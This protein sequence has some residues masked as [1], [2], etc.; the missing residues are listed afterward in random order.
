MSTFTWWLVI[1]GSPIV[2][3][4]VG[5]FL[6]YDYGVKQTEERWSEAVARAE[7]ADRY[8]TS[9]PINRETA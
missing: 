3:F 9:T 6:G 8:P 1:I 5:H 4:I 2:A 7:W